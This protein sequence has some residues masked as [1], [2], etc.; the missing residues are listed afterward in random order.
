MNK[1]T[2][3][4]AVKRRAKRRNT[5]DFYIAST[6]MFLFFC[7]LISLIIFAAIKISLKV[8]SAP[9]EITYQFSKSD[10][11]QTISSFNKK[12]KLSDVSKFGTYFVS[13]DDISEL[14]GMR[15][16]GDY[17]NISLI[18]KTGNEYIRFTVGS[19]NCVINGTNCKMDASAY[20]NRNEV[21]VPAD[22]FVQYYSGVS[23]EFDKEKMILNIGYSKS[24][25]THFAVREV[26]KL[27]EIFDENEDEA[28]GKNGVSLTECS[29]ISD[30]SQYE[31]YMNPHECG[32]YI[33]LVNDAHP[34]S[35]TYVPPNLTQISDSNIQ[36]SVS[37]C[38]Y[39]A[40]SLEALLKEAR[41]EGINTLTVT[42]AYKDYAS[43]NSEFSAL[44]TKE[45][46]NNP[47][48]SKEEAEAN[49]LMY[50]K[51]PGAS[52]FQ[53]GLSCTVLNYGKNEN[54]FIGTEEAAWLAENCWKF[55]FVLRYPEDK[56]EITGEDFSAS[57]FRYV[58][59]FHAENMKNRGM[60]LE[61]YAESLK[62][63]S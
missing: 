39:A 5:A 1:K 52:E 13:L 60:C 59:R 15:Y 8:R 20:E 61:E 51:R 30:L 24:S 50:A 56:T 26:T 40:K 23:A 47:E 10:D 11:E 31:K 6:V 27:I 45:M 16:I 36:K 58:G 48:L 43:M 4:S 46:N 7:A 54:D 2:G 25:G 62:T 32:I 33:S 14:L 42:E 44:V 28:N 29:F 49:V 19:H 34:L 3:K 17:G 57:R 37:L 35:P 41:A 53:T 63:N 9:G 38:L 55:G 18:S 21:F 12:Y 22:V